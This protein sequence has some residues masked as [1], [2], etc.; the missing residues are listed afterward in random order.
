M[1]LMVELILSQQK[2]RD[3]DPNYAVSDSWKLSLEQS[4]FFKSQLSHLSIRS[5]YLLPL[6]GVHFFTFDIDR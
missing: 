4:R 3:E 1:L 6:T 5:F 2:D